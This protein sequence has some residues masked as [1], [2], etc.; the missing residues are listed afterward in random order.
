M[1][2]RF[3]L[4]GVQGGKKCFSI[5]RCS[6]A[7]IA[8]NRFFPPENPLRIQPHLWVGFED[9]SPNQSNSMGFII[10]PGLWRTEKLKENTNLL[11]LAR[12]PDDL[13]IINKRSQDD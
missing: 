5:H 3:A 11:Y 13:R 9:L 7:S 10:L 4:C 6:P 2:H 8:P 12:F 1:L